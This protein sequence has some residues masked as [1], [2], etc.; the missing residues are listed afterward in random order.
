MKFELF[1][2]IYYNKLYQEILFRK[3]IDRFIIMWSNIKE[4]AL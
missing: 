1:S 2:T 4:R 3:S